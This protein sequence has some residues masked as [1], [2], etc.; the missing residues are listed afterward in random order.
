[1]TAL[2][3]KVRGGIIISAKLL[4]TT[5]ITGSNTALITF[6]HERAAMLFEDYAMQHSLT[7]A[8]HRVKVELLSKPTWPTSIPLKKAI[9]DHGH[10]R[11]LTVRNF[12]RNISPEAL[13]RD[14]HVCSVMVTDRIESMCMRTDSVLELRFE[15]IWTAGKAYGILTS[16][17][18]YRQCKVEFS[19]D[20][21]AQPLDILNK[22]T[23]PASNSTQ[24]KSSRAEEPQTFPAESPGGNDD[25]NNALNPTIVLEDG[26]EP[27][28]IREPLTGISTGGPKT[29]NSKNPIAGV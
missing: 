24:L 15:S 25:A 29:V 18:V 22:Q 3:D 14:L 26:D 9:Y 8:G 10:T 27:L 1:M 6:L 12:P 16:W 13:R 11:C 19:P 2:L 23:D 21:C 5:T 17:R 4:N 20:P 28:V 7:F